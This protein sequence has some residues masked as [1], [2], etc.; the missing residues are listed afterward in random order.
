MKRENVDLFLKIKKSMN[1]EKEV[2]TPSTKD[3]IEKKGVRKQN[4]KPY[5]Q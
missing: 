4:T 5:Y 1:F 3:E 2:Y